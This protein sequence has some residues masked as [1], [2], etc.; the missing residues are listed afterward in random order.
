MSLF[1]KRS[2]RDLYKELE[3]NTDFDEMAA[4]RHLSEEF[5]D[6]YIDRFSTVDL[7]AHQTLSE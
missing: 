2:K 6:K 4:K 5:L 7:A 3:A 1:K